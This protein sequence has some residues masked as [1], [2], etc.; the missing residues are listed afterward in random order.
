MGSY[1]HGQ[2]QPVQ[3]QSQQVHA[4]LTDVSRTTGPEALAPSHPPDPLS[5]W[6]TH[7]GLGTAVHLCPAVRSLLCLTIDGSTQ[8]GGGG[9]RGV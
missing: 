9:G 8:G 3:L 5:P 2:S 4:M 6:L 7:L 1:E